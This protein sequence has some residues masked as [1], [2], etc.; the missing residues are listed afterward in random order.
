MTS[1]PPEPHDWQ[2]AAHRFAPQESCP[3]PNRV[4]EF[5][6][7][8]LSSGEEEELRAHLAL[9]AACRE[10][11]ADARLF[12]SGKTGLGAEKV[13]TVRSWRAGW[14]VAAA[15]LLAISGL[16]LWDSRPGDRSGLARDQKLRALVAEFVAPAPPPPEAPA[17]ESELVFRGEEVLSE[18]AA[19]L[20]SY[21]RKEWPAAIAALSAHL[22]SHPGDLE[23]RFFRGVAHLVAGQ[24]PAAR[25][26]LVAALRD[27]SL[28]EQAAWYLALAELA[29]GAGSDGRARLAELAK[30]DG[31]RAP[32]ARALLA[33]LESER[34]P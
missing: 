27:P 2:V 23:A 25:A 1:E 4:A 8:R 32:A 18:R 3:E 22:A 28:A 33:K 11:A 19:A 14:M 5:Y 21:R 20:A 29:G 24:A 12:L 9:C 7:G 13:A 34:L 16:L 10:V 15:S 30:G 31:T 6:L 26:D 17:R